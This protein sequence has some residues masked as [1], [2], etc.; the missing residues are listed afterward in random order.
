MEGDKE[1][2]THTIPLNPIR[3]IMKK[4][5]PYHISTEAVLTIRDLLEGVLSETTIKAVRRFENLNKCREEQ[6]LPRLKRLNAWAVKNSNYNKDFINRQKINN[7]GLQPEEIAIPTGGNMSAD[8]STKP[9]SKATD[10]RR[11]VV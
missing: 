10:D 3:Q 11:E 8:N 4:H 5:C 6:G 9:D 1:V 7:R 2:R